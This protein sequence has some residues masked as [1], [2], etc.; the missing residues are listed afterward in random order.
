MGGIALHDGNC[1]GLL[2]GGCTCSGEAV[3]IKH[4]VICMIKV[5]E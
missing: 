4:R 5:E 1:E 3:K 2:G